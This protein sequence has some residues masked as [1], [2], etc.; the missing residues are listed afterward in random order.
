MFKQI[1]ASQNSIADKWNELH[2]HWR[3]GCA[4]NIS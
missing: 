3:S 2:R 4:L 1:L